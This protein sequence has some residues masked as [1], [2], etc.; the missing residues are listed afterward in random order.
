MLW[1]GSELSRNQHGATGGIVFLD[2]SDNGLRDGQIELLATALGSACPAL[3][4]LDLVRVLSALL[5]PLFLSTSFS[6]L[7]SSS[8]HSSKLTCFSS[9]PQGRNRLSARGA[10]AIG[11]HVRDWQVCT[12]MLLRNVWYDPTNIRYRDR[13]CV[14]CC[15]LRTLCPVLR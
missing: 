12:P 9:L 1:K 4:H 14:S 11:Q 13:L 8:N 6:F 15:E 10:E 2:L 5:S 3:R 7:L